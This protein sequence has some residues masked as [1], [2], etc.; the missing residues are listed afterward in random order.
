MRSLYTRAGPS[1][2]GRPTLLRRRVTQNQNDAGAQRL[3]YSLAVAFRGGQR[4]KGRMDR[5]DWP[6]AS[7][8]MRGL[9]KDVGSSERR[10]ANYR[11]YAGS[12]ALY[13]CGNPSHAKSDGIG[14]RNIGRHLRHGGQLCRRGL[15]GKGAASSRLCTGGGFRRPIRLSRESLRRKCGAVAVPRRFVTC[16]V[17]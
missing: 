15:S 1:G 16:C 7:L 17:G 2:Q 12:S 13:C 10:N 9:G 3:L 11:G 5:P 8:K 4:A 6:H 14:L